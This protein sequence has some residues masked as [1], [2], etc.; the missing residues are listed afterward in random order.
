MLEH[1]EAEHRRVD[2]QHAAAVLDPV[3]SK[4]SSAARIGVELRVVA[5][6]RAARRRRGALARRTLARSG[7]QSGPHLTA[8]RARARAGSRGA[9][10]PPA[11][12]PGSARPARTPGVRPPGRSSQSPDPGRATP[13][14]ADSRQPMPAR[15]RRC[16]SSRSVSRSRRAR[17]SADRR[18]ISASNCSSLPSNVWVESVVAR[19][20]TDRAGFTPGLPHGR[21]LTRRSSTGSVVAIAGRACR[22]PHHGR[23][24]RDIIDD[25]GAGADVRSGADR[26]LADHLRPGSDARPRLDRRPPHIPGHAGRSS[27][28]GRSPRP[29]G[30]RPGR[31]RRTARG[32]CTR[33]GARP[34]DR[35]SR[36]APAPSPAGGQSAAA[37][38]LRRP[39]ASP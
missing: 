3:A 23:S 38:A 25:H 17:L 29:S 10:S 9:G 15:L 24:G 31:R 16:R 37:R 14:L 5:H 22:D 35:R 7:R 13:S 1:L 20:R 34:P 26:D 12:A 36:S 2:R 4:V 19:P 6:C 32:R 8:E 21:K 33:R 11:A 28:T 18:S 30:S 39:V 27:R